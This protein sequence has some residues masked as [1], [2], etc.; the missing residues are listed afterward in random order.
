VSGNIFGKEFR[1]QVIGKIISE[2]IS[3]AEAA[4]RYEIPVKN[5]YR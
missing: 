5:I 2:G 4:K 1:E 3:G